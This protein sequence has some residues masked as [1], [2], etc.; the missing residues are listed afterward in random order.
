M[1]NDGMDDLADE[2]DFSEACR[3]RTARFD[4]QEGGISRSP[5]G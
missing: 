5:E 1:R 2:L 4:N 3:W